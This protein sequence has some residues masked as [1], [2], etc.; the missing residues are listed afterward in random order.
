MDLKYCKRCYTHKLIEEFK[1]KRTPLAELKE[2][3]MCNYCSIKLK[4]SMKN[5][6]I[7]KLQSELE[8]IQELTPDENVDLIFCKKCS[9]FKQLDDF[10]RKITVNSKLKIWKMC[11][12]CSSNEKKSYHKNKEKEHKKAQEVLPANLKYCKSCQKKQPRENFIRLQQNKT[13]LKEWT[14]CNNCSDQTKVLYNKNKKERSQYQQEYNKK[15]PE[16]KLNYRVKNRKKDLERKKENLNNPICNYLNCKL[17]KVLRLYN[18]KCVLHHG[19][20]QVFLNLFYN[21]KM[22]SKERAKKHTNMTHNRHR[23]DFL[24]T[25]N[26]LILLYK[27]QNG[28]CYYC[29]ITMLL[30]KN[31]YNPDSISIDRLD[32]YLAYSNK[33]CVFCCVWCNRAKNATS[34]KTYFNVL[35]ILFNHYQKRKQNLPQHEVTLNCFDYL[36]NIRISLNKDALKPWSVNE[37]RIALHRQNFCCSLTGIEFCL[38]DVLYCPLKPSL[39]RIDS[40]IKDHGV[41]EN[42]QIICRFLNLAKNSMSMFDFYLSLDKRAIPFT[43]FFTESKVIESRNETTTCSDLNCTECSNLEEHQQKLYTIKFPKRYE[44]KLKEFNA[45]DNQFKPQFKWTYEQALLGG[46]MK[47][48]MELNVNSDS[49]KKI[50]NEYDEDENASTSENEKCKASKEE[51]DKYIDV[52]DED[53]GE[54]LEEKEEESEADEDEDEYIDIEDEENEAAEDEDDYIDIEEG[55]SEADEDEDECVDIEEEDEDKEEEKEKDKKNETLKE[56]EKEEESEADEDEDEECIDI[57]DEYKD[58]HEYEHEVKD[59][60]EVQVDTK[61]NLFIQNHIQFLEQHGHDEYFKNV[62]YYLDIDQSNY[63]VKSGTKRKRSEEVTEVTQ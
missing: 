38:C 55:E 52:K 11:N 40:S 63:L 24:P 54:A 19:L 34:E 20:Y 29:K 60:D 39:D 17:K 43:K 2:W 5:Q 33:N 6:K 28:I 49:D 36:Q 30:T 15:N 4:E 53:E 42:C 45:S 58:E 18:G 31:V 48:I 25:I 46:H 12:S 8:R 22:T 13:T 10:K 26:D 59:K 57:E 41:R 56:K 62:C 47:Q 50:Y 7:I 9:T 23:I 1:R 35:K 14:T 51:K 37:I 61:Q 44:K 27:K 21:M 3:D 16:T 32:S